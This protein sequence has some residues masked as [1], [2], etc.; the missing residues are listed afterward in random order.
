MIVEG[1]K[2]EETTKAYE[3][4]TMAERDVMMLCSE[5]DEETR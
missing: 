4:P 1:R 3:T 2:E 5:Q